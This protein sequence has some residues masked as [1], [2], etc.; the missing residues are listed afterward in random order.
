MPLN[1][2]SYNLTDK[3]LKLSYWYV[4]HKLVIRQWLVIGFLAVS[5]L[6][7]AYI[8]WQAVMFTVEYP[9]EQAMINNLIVGDGQTATALEAKRP[10]NIQI[11]GLQAIANDTGRNDY[12]FQIHNPN[13]NW[14]AEFDYQLVGEKSNTPLK[15]SFALPNETKYLMDLGVENLGG[16][17]RIANLKWQ[18][19]DDYENLKNARLNFLIENQNFI[20]GQ[21][22]GDPNRV[23]FDLQNLSAYSYWEVPITAILSNGGTI[24]GV[25]YIVLKQVKSGERQQVE[26]LWQNQLPRIDSIEIIPDLNILDED[27]IMPMSGG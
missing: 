7:F 14:L 4:T 8:I 1:A 20:A 15:S 11:S 24:E 13:S 18:R 2:P 27:N 19:I 10:A 16:E 6:L 25:N 12:Y 17:L 21:K 9:N 23:V 5:I 26:I 22:A 3:Q